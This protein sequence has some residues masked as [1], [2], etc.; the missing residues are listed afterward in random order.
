VVAPFANAAHFCE[1]HREYS[2]IVFPTRRKV[3]PKAIG[4]RPLPGPTVVSIALDD[5]RVR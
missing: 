4:G 2:D 5:V 1:R 3:V